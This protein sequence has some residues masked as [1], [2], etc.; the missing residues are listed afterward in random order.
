MRV[1]RERER[2]GKKP[3]PTG[4]ERELGINSMMTFDSASSSFLALLVI[5]SKNESAK[6]KRKFFH[7]SHWKNAQNRF[8]SLEF[9]HVTHL[10]D[11]KS[12]VGQ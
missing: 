2:E 10:Q 1:K 11:M 5:K 9:C 7:I 3:Q 6:F 12:F 4:R 8:L